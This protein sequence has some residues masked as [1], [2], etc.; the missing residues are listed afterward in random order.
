M[1]TCIQRSTER[2][3]DLMVDELTES[4]LCRIGEVVAG[5]MGL[6]FPRERWNALESAL[7]KAAPSLGFRDSVSLARWLVEPPLEEARLERLTPFLTIGETHFFRDEKLFRAFE[8]QLLPQLMASRVREGRRLR[9]WSAGCATGEEPY[10]IAIVL[11]KTI[12]QL[13]DWLVTILA[14]DINR[15]F[16]KKA[17]KGVY[18]QW[19]F[20]VVPERVQ[21][22]YFTSN[23]EG[24]RIVGDIKKMVKFG[25]LNLAGC[26]Y[27]HPS[28]DTEAVDVIFCRNVLMYFTPEWQKRVVDQL[29][30]SLADDGLLVVSP[31]EASIID[32]PQLVSENVPGTVLFR[33]SDKPRPRFNGL[34]FAVPEQEP[35]PWDDSAPDFI[36]LP[37]PTVEDDATLVIPQLI[38][39]APDVDSA[40]ALAQERDTY[41]EALELYDRG[42]YPA[43]V[44]KLLP[45]SGPGEEEAEDS[46]RVAFLLSKAYANQGDLEEALEWSQRA[47]IEDKLNPESHYLHGTILH[48]MGRIEDAV[49]AMKR[50]V[51]LDPDFVVA[52]FALGILHRQR[53]R[54]K[55]RDRHYRIALTILS[56]YSSDDTVPASEGITAGRLS[57]LIEAMSRKEN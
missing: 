36:P 29:F 51:F 47:V 5:H 52:H 46:G 43:V 11:N 18:S 26:D 9:F 6:H 22:C 13:T 41:E 53:G 15:D 49:L 37:W 28:N 20:R 31:A 35:E 24:Y 34:L 7:R 40:D 57:E 30:R 21:Q 32:H 56:R 33:K 14:T 42:D 8:E 27:P 19:S 48:E 16:L 17:V 3:V 10:S 4:L 54:F 2:P 1:K 55:D 44:S 23:G 25:H 38:V 39:E 50:A 12:P 45:V